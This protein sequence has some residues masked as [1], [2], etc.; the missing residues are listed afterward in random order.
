[1][2]RLRNDSRK[3]SAPQLR[4]A[5]ELISSYLRTLPFTLTRGQQKAYQQIAQDL[6]SASPMLRLLQGDV[7]SGKTVVAALSALH[8]I[9]SGYQAAL[10]A[11]TEILAEQHLLN[12]K[13]WFT[14]L[15]IKVGWL[16]GRSKASERRQLL[17]NLADGSCKLLI[18]THA[19]SLIHI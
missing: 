1:M 11:P 19:L 10:M 13:N 14:P 17:D 16:S 6:A 5:D 4:A 9:A 15:G 2:R 12:F 7:G 18:G 3:Q 8:A